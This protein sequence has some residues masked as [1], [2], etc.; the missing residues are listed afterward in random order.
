M[1]SRPLP[2]I[3]EKYANSG[4]EITSGG[5]RTPPVSSGENSGPPAIMAATENLHS[6][7]LGGLTVICGHRKELNCS[8]GIVREVDGTLT[9]LMA[10]RNGHLPTAACCCNRQYNK[11]GGAQE[12]ANKE[13]IALL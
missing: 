10:V 1:A 8:S 9:E 13:R 7:N 6:S 2:A 5:R 4:R 3:H 11:C 12:A